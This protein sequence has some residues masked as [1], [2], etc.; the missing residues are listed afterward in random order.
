MIEFIRP[1][2]NWLQQ[3][4][5]HYLT[6]CHLLQTGHSTGNILTS[7][8]NP[9]YSLKY[10]SLL[11]SILFPLIFLRHGPHGKHFLKNACLL[12]HYPAI[13]VLLLERNFGNV[14]TEPLPNNCHMRHNILCCQ[15][16]V[17]SW[18]LSCTQS[19][20]KPKK[21]RSVS[22]CVCKSNWQL[23]CKVKTCSKNDCNTWQQHT[24]SLRI[25]QEVAH[26]TFL[27]EIKWLNISWIEILEPP[28][29]S[30]A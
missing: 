11:Y 23:A 24:A 16:L 21:L 1:L 20:L 30:S 27:Q 3:F 14:F 6:H 29:K 18:I 13:Y 17:L 28:L 15:Y 9:L 2:Y 8:W 10:Y 19:R 5:N 22:F 26:T 7:N 12:A 4:T 25:W